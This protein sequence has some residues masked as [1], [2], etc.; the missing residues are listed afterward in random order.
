MIFN[1]VPM[2]APLSFFQRRG[3]VLIVCS[4]VF[5][6]VMIFCATTPFVWELGGQKSESYPE[7]LF[8]FL[9]LPLGVVFVLAA[10]ANFWWRNRDQA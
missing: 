9:G 10:L 3:S 6:D 8:A 4:I 5:F 1:V 7:L 2:T